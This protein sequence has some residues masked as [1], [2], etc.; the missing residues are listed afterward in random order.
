[1]Q[2]SCNWW[3]NLFNKYF[4]K[5]VPGL[6][7]KTLAETNSDISHINDLVLNQNKI[8]KAFWGQG[9]NLGPL[10]FAINSCNILF[11]KDV[12]DIASKAVDNTS[13]TARHCKYHLKNQLT[14]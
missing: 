12:I 10:L 8:Q 11:T 1:M 13:Y 4:G 3:K 14:E 2:R 6:G 5:L 9:S 7:L